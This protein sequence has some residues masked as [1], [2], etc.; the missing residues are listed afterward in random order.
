[1]MTFWL[2]YNNKPLTAIRAPI[3]TT[4]QQVKNKALQRYRDFPFA[5]NECAPFEFEYR[6]QAAEVRLFV[7]LA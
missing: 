4:F 7:D 5:S 2:Y 3:G 6:I 1:M